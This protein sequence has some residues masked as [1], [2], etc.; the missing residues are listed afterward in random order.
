MG[1]AA[2]F[3]FSCS[4]WILPLIFSCFPPF[5]GLCQARRSRPIKLEGATVAS[6]CVQ[7]R[8]SYRSVLGVEASKANC[9]NRSYGAGDGNRNHVR[10]L[11]NDRYHTALFLCLRLHLG[12]IFDHANSDSWR[13]KPEIR[14]VASLRRS[15]CHVDPKLNN[16]AVMFDSGPR[17][18][19]LLFVRHVYRYRVL[20]CPQVERNCRELIDNGNR[21]PCLRQV[22]A[23][24]VG[25]A[26]VADVR[27]HMT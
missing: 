19:D 24:Q 12:I 13:P 21:Q 14:C 5:S 9:I 11:G 2:F 4:H 18:Q 10:N 20:A 7:N 26:C 22:D 15:R 23:L 25:V 16:E 3:C 27:A 6:N 1:A 8:W 17:H